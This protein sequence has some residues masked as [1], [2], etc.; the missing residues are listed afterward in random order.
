MP[1]I[2][3]GRQRRRQPVRG[4]GAARPGGG[5]PGIALQVL[6]YPVTDCDLETTSYRDP[7]NQALLTRDSMIWFWDHYAPDR[8]ARAAPGRVTAARRAAWRTCRPR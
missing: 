6:V 2:V 4:H 3:A 8:E 1:L 7:A 5:R